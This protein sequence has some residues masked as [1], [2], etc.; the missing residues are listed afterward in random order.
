M[1]ASNSSRTLGSQRETD[2]CKGNRKSMGGICMVLTIIFLALIIAEFVIVGC[3]AVAGIGRLAYYLFQGVWPVGW[4]NLRGWALSL[5]VGCV[6]LLGIAVLTQA[7]ATT[8]VIE[9]ANGNEVEGSI[10]ELI[11]V[12][13]NGRDEWI[14]LR[15]HDRN[16]PVLLFLAGGPGGSQMAAVRHDLAELEK[17]FVVVNWDQPGAGKSFGAAPADQLTV[18]MYV[19]DGCA[20]A[21]Y[22]SN[23]FYWDSIYL[24]GESW[25]SA[26]GIMMADREPE[27]FAGF[28]GT[29]QMVDFIETEVTDY[30]LAM[31]LAEESGDE[32]KFQSLKENGMPPYKQAW[33][34]AEY[35]GYL[36]NIMTQ[37]P[38][39][40]NAGYNTLRDVFSI[41]Y[42]VLDRVNYFLGMLTT[43]NHVYPQLYGID[44]REDYTELDV[45]V[46]FFLGKHDINAPTYLAEEYYS[47]VDAP[48]KKMV[49]FEHS[50]HS[51]WINESHLFVQ[52]VLSFA[53]LD[54]K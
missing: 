26:L 24:V 5:C 10:A 23:R 7:M 50:G 36:A 52:E 37:N 33:K 1:Q 16:A 38:E 29:G 44:L 22:L 35:L 4:I 31:K 40:N 8:P 18:D 43:F 11:E 6:S 39:I 9:D 47:A 28:I 12:N 2:G 45:Q 49:W 48:Q 15:G 53:G 20:L 41:E 25:G 42:G 34:S 32:K 54:T 30:K 27:L 3:M 46:S 17:H 51:P 21:E 14:S 19:D 13:L